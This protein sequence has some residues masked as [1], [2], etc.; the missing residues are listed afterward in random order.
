MTLLYEMIGR[1][2]VLLVRRR[3]GRQLRIA[4][5]VGVAAA[6]VGA[7]LIASREVEEG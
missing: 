7:Y 2:V 3:F 4:A 1:V 6:L 5:G